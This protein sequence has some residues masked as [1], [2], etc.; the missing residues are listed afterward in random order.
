[1][2]QNCYH[3]ANNYRHR[4]QISNS[5]WP[6]SFCT[7]LTVSLSC[8]AI[9][10]PRSD[11]TLKLLVLVGKIKNATTVTSLFSDCIQTI[12]QHIIYE[13]QPHNNS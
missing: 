10:C 5:L 2:T 13:Y 7:A 8:L 11:S 3:K 6:M 1:M 12:K 9:A 4:R